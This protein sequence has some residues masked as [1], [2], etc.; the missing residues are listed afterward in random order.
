MRWVWLFLLAVAGALGGY[1]FTRFEGRPPEIRTA[2]TEAYVSR[3]YRHSFEISDAG[4]GLQQVRIW[5]D[6]GGATH[7]L[8]DETYEGN[9]FTG[10]ALD[11]DRHLEVV[12]DPKA[13]GL[14]DGAATLHAEARDF[15]WRGNVAHASA[16]LI[17]DT[18]APRLSVATGLTYVNRGG[19]EALVYSVNEQVVRDGVELAGAFFPGFPHPAQPGQRVA[20][21]AFPHDAPGDAVPR[22]VAVDR[23]GNRSDVSAS[24]RLL[25]RGFPADSIELSDA[26][27]QTKVS[28]LLGGSD[29]P[30]VD[31]YLKINRDMRERNAEQLRELCS[32]PNPEPLWRGAFRQMPNTATSGAIGFGARRTYLYQGKPVDQQTHLGVDMASTARDLVP[33]ANDGRVVFAEPLGIYGN[34]VLLDHG[35]GL[36]TL[37]GHLSEF[38]VA[39]GDIVAPG[40][41]LGRSGTTGLAGGDHLHFSV[42][43]HGVFV[44]PLEW[45]DE[46]WIREH[47]A[48]K[49]GAAVPE[50]ADPATQ[51]GAQPGAGDAASAGSRRALP[52]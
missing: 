9:L 30:L 38:G 33:A 3:D 22:V 27:M 2:Q 31:A 35:L 45:F 4:T 6:A 18:Q 8:K 15:S 42:L 24:I 47:I 1:L 49:L 46:R 21:Y 7:T 50:G 26:F 12:I 11:I 41:P 19:S 48:P 23:A 14:A 13:L 10:A 34:A 43:V 37:Y 52:G 17:L 36:F 44:D 20:L 28:E 40:D 51:P 16:P 39:K 32:S 29:G 25:E 5:L